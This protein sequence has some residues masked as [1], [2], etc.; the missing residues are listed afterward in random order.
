MLLSRL[1]QR[2]SPMILEAKLRSGDLVDQETHLHVIGLATAVYLPSPYSVQ[3]LRF[4]LQYNPAPRRNTLLHS[5]CRVPHSSAVGTLLGQ[6]VTLASQ[7]L[8][9]PANLYLGSMEHLRQRNYT[10]CL[11]AQ[12]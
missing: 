3:H 8:P 6:T 9:W 10:R 1:F 2:L 5:S 12:Q 7:S 11:F 4:P